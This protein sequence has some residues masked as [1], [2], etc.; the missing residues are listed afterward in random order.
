MGVGGINSWSALAY[1]LEPYR[2]P[3]D[4]PYSFAYVLRPVR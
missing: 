3:S 2:I 1:P 4:R